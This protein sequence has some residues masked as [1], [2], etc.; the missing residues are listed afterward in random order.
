[1]AAG[2]MGMTRV[3]VPDHT[4]AGSC[5]YRRMS[6]ADAAR[7]DAALTGRHDGTT[8]LDLAREMGVSRRTLYRWRGARVHEV[9]VGGWVAT[10]VTRPSHA[11]GIPVQCTPWR[12]DAA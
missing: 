9:R 10:F 8:M 12:E 7:L 4:G 11:D 5:G 6:L 2:G 3:S 1:M